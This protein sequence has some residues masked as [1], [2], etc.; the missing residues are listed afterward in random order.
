MGFLVNNQIND[1]QG[2]GSTQNT[3]FLKIYILL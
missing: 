2:L 3:D 1:I